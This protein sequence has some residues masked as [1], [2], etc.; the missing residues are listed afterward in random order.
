MMIVNHRK[1]LGLAGT[2]RVPLPVLQEVAR[3]GISARLQATAIVPDSIV[4]GPINAQQSRIHR[5]EW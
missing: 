3:A 1:M 2:A 4:Q 5:T